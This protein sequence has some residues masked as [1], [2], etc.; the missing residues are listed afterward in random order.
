MGD[1]VRYR[2]VTGVEETWVIGAIDADYIIACGWPLEWV[3]ISSLEFKKAATDEEHHALL[4][5]LSTM[6]DQ[7]DPRCRAAKRELHGT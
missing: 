2:S 3:P 1:H 6:N 7:N 5:E 4:L